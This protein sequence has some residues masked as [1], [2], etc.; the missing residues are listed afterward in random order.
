ML[1]YM[2][3]QE[4]GEAGTTEGHVGEGSTFSFDELRK[5]RIKQAIEQVLKAKYG[6]DIVL[7]RDVNAAYRVAM[8]SG[9]KNPWRIV[10]NKVTSRLQKA[11]TVGVPHGE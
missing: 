9:E 4:A 8:W 10:V 11:L 6:A 1:S 5:I 3:M 2:S 7:D